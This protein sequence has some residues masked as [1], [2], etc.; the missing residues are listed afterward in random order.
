MGMINGLA[1]DILKIRSEGQNLEFQGGD[2]GCSAR[3][4]QRQK[5]R[6]NISRAQA[7]RR[8]SQ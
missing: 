6:R 3:G 5:T 7:V 1:L 4:A 8:V 2:G